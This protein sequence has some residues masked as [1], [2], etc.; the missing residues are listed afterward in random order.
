MVK[1]EKNFITMLALFVSIGFFIIISN[2]VFNYNRYFN[3]IRESKPAVYVFGKGSVSDNTKHK[4]V[5]ANNNELITSSKKYASKILVLINE[6]NYNKVYFETNQ[7]LKE[8]G[9]VSQF[10]AYMNSME[11][12][13]G[14]LNNTNINHCSVNGDNNEVKITYNTFSCKLNKKVYLTIWVKRTNNFNLSG[15]KFAENYW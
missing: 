14:I 2:Y 7:E 9:N 3:L 12:T 11:N 15:I 8:K 5:T 13:Y 10:I 6:H 1:K 4:T